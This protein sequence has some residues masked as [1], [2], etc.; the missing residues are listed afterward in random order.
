MTETPTPSGAMKRKTGFFDLPGELRNIIYELYK[1]YVAVQIGCI[2]QNPQG[3]RDNALCKA[4]PALM[5]EYKGY[6]YTNSTFMLDIRDSPTMYDYRSHADTECWKQ[7]AAWLRVL[8][9]EEIGLIRKLRFYT[10]LHVVDV[11][12]PGKKEKPQ[13]LAVEIR[14]KANAPV[15]FNQQLPHV[16]EFKRAMIERFWKLEQM[17]RE[18]MKAL[19]K[20]VRMMVSAWFKR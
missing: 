15:Q 18:D 3:M 13:K 7:W 20:V 17:E 11:L 12:L 9:D 6:Y 10:E 19:A 8:T 2:M 4:H 1:P 16:K 14:R 5:T